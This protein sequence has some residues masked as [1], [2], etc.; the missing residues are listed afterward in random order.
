MHISIQK[1]SLHHQEALIELYRN[2]A[3][4]PGGIIRKPEEITEAYIAGF[5]ESAIANGLMLVALDRDK[6]VGEI[7]AYTPSIYAFQHLLTD[8]TIVI[9]PD[10][11]GQGIGKRLFGQFLDTVKTEYRHI[12][13]IELFTRE[14]NLRN[15]QF[16]ESLGFVNEGGQR[17]KI[18]VDANHFETPLHMA[19]FNENYAPS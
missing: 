2:V 4:T 15:V 6:V 10:Y 18:L 8:L 3:V 11:Q 7:H 12:L 13:R 9:D 14:H 5:T 17:N 19:W 1:G 16:Y